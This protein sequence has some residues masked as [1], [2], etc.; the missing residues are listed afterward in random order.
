MIVGAMTCTRSQMNIYVSFNSL[1]KDII[2]LH[3]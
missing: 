2:L 1:P 3:F